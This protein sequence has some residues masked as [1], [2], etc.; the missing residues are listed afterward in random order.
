MSRFQRIYA[1][2]VTAM[3]AS[4]ILFIAGFLFGYLTHPVS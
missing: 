3:S 1:I 4:V 2:T